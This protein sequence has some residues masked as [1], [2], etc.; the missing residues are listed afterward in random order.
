[1]ARLPRLAWPVHVH[2]ARAA[3]RRTRIASPCSRL[4]A[5]ETDGRSSESTGASGSSARATGCGEPGRTRGRTLISSQ[6]TAPPVS[7][8]ACALPSPPLTSPSW[9]VAMGL[10]T[11]RDGGAGASWPRGCGPGLGSS[12]ELGPDTSPRGPGPAILPTPAY[13]PP[14]GSEPGPPPT[15]PWLWPA[16]GSRALIDQSAGSRALDAVRAPPAPPP[17]CAVRP[18]LAKLPPRLSSSAATVALRPAAM[19]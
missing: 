2:A 8:S 19:V 15:W 1:V 4:S 13:V 12:R 9:A 7:S 10:G 11:Q 17:T 3:R 5:S 18:P 14:H 6:S 16:C